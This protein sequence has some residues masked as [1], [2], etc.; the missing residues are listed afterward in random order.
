[1]KRTLAAA[2]LLLLF[3]L[4]SCASEPPND[5]VA[6]SYEAAD[7]LFDGA[8]REIGEDA[9]V[10]YGVFTPAGH[11]AASSPFGRIFAEHVASRLA[12]RGVKVVEV[13]LREAIAVREGG[14]YALSD[15]VRDV[16]RRVRARAALA[17]SYVATS[18]YALVTARLVDVTTGFVLSSWDKRIPLRRA[19]YFLF[20]RRAGDGGHWSLSDPLERVFGPLW[21]EY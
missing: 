8:R 13:R 11:P 17:G 9:P 20:E 19:D 7:T 10:V 1:M 21:R 4:A 6:L 15:D 14:P 3:A 5:F 16:A 2:R 12:Q 18:G